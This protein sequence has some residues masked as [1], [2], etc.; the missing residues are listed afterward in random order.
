MWPYLKM[1]LKVKE[2]LDRP[3]DIWLCTRKAAEYLGISPNALRIKVHRLEVK[4]FKIGR[5]LRF[6]KSDLDLLIVDCSKDYNDY[7]NL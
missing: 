7:Q 3:Q 6:K 4:F 2:K 1:E 5:R